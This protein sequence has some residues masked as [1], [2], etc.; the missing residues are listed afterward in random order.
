MK[1]Y[2]IFYLESK[3]GNGKLGKKLKNKID[4][5]DYQKRLIDKKKFLNFGTYRKQEGLRL[6]NCLFY[7]HLTRKKKGKK[8][9]FLKV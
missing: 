3:H 2:F 1:K 4:L 6:L 9:Y 7:L 5:L 8:K